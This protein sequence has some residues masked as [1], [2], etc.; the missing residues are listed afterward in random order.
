MA[1]EKEI[2][3]FERDFPKL[4]EDFEGKFVVY[5]GEG[6]LGSYDTFDAAADAALHSFGSQPF[7][8]RQVVKDAPAPRL[9]ASVAFRPFHAA[10]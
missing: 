10:A 5:H 9:P 1:L 3:A 7:L 8:I 4:L 2:A 6:R